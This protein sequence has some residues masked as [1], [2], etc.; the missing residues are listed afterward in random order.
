MIGYFTVTEGENKNTEVYYFMFCEYSY[1]QA[2]CPFTVE[3][4][5]SGMWFMGSETL[6]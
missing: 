2:S 5:V 1:S 4:S 6:E 3:V